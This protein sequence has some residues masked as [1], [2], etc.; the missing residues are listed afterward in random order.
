MKRLLLTFAVTCSL[1]PL[2]AQEVLTLEQ[3]LKIGI[4]NNL[5]LEARRNDIRKGKHTISE[6]R[7]KLLPQITATASFND[8]FNPPVSVTDGSA[9]G[10][11]CTTRP[12]T[13]HSR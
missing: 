8:N 3:C 1:F 11:P 12:S 13:P 2:K 6:N 5:S 4:E 10:N 7:A 9:Y